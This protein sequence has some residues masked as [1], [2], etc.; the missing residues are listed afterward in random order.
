MVDPPVRGSGLRRSDSIDFCAREILT[1]GLGGGDAFW[2]IA[3][4]LGWEGTLPMPPSWVSATARTPGELAYHEWSGGVAPTQAG[5]WAWVAASSDWAAVCVAVAA[6]GVSPKALCAMR[7]EFLEACRISLSGTPQARVMSSWISAHLGW[8]RVVPCVAAV[9]DSGACPDCTVALMCID[10][11]PPFA[12]VQPIGPMQHLL[13]KAFPRRCQ[14]RELLRF[15]SAYWNNYT[16]VEWFLRCAVFCSLGGF[17]RHHNESSVPPLGAR[18]ALYDVCF[19]DGSM[20]L[21]AWMRAPGSGSALHSM[22]CT[23]LVVLQD[24]VVSTVYSTPS[25]AGAYNGFVDWTLFVAHVATATTAA[26]RVFT[27]TRLLHAPTKRGEKRI[28]GQQPGSRTTIFAPLGDEGCLAVWLTG[29]VTRDQ[30][31]WDAVIRASGALLPPVGVVPNTRKTGWGRASCLYDFLCKV[32]RGGGGVC[33]VLEQW[34]CRGFGT[35]AARHAALAALGVSHPRALATLAVLVEVMRARC[36]VALSPLPQSAERKQL[37]AVRVRYESCPQLP[38]HA[39]ALVVCLF[40]ANVKNPVVRNHVGGP[41]GDGCTSSR[42]QLSSGVGAGGVVYDDETCR[43]YCNAHTRTGGGRRSTGGASLLRSRLCAL[44]PLWVGSVVGQVAT[45]GGALF[46]LCCECACPMKLSK[47]QKGGSFLL[48][49]ACAKHE[50]LACVCC[51]KVPGGG[52]PRPPHNWSTVAR[53]VYGGEYTGPG[54]L[55][56]GPLCGPCSRS[57]ESKRRRCFESTHIICV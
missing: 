47:P 31:E 26:Q 5:W 36:K 37:A 42:H 28:R 19:L 39:G 7:L 11:R 23:L 43:V 40:C 38:A 14:I 55:G 56:L 53:L 30:V 13:R 33:A 48:C 35:H 21:A 12:A 18:Q 25:Q 24:A 57:V 27:E 1:L 17:Y 29:N 32:R 8:P 22:Q 46:T 15:V 45:I 16:E 34:A 9:L 41:A 3:T 49:E 44:T 20:S 50:A 10:P 2:V 51:G 6:Y 54:N 52:R 4:N